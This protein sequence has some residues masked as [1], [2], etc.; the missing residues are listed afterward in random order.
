MC[1]VGYSCL[2]G[3]RFSVKVILRVVAGRRLG[4]EG[5]LTAAKGEDGEDEAGDG[6][7]GSE[8]GGTSAR[9]DHTKELVK[10]THDRL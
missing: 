4:C 2:P 8:D 5:R 10:K 6:I 9:L 3:N 1:A 7:D